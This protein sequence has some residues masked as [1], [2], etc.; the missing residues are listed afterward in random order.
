MH[1]FAFCV[2]LVICAN[3]IHYYSDANLKKTKTKYSM[4]D[5]K[6]RFLTLKI[7]LL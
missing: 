7:M 5:H 1:P 3:R 2:H 6:L 4:G